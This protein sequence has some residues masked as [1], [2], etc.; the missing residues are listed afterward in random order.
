MFDKFQIIKHVYSGIDKIHSS[1]TVGKTDLCI[2]SRY[3]LESSLK[4]PCVS[5]VL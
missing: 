3:G 4:A 2:G 1:S 5:C